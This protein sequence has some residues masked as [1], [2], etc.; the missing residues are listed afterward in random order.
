MIQWWRQKSRIYTTVVIIY[1]L[2]L[3][4]LITGNVGAVRMPVSTIMMYQN[5][6]LGSQIIN[7]VYAVF[8]V[9]PSITLFRLRLLISKH[10]AHQNERRPHSSRWDRHKAREKSSKDVWS[11][12]W[13]I[14]THN[15]TRLFDKNEPVSF[16][17]HLGRHRP[18]DLFANIC[19]V[20]NKLP[21]DH[22]PVQCP[23]SHH[24]HIRADWALR[25]CLEVHREQTQ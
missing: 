13:I 21:D 10:T 5:T 7:I 8:Y 9:I 23:H 3:C 22:S 1:V 16:T 2:A 17:C 18:K 11:S 4:V 20:Q 24:L 25:S 19:T 14:L 6:G 12:F 15:H